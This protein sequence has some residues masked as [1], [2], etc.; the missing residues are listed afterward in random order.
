MK[1]KQT[2]WIVS[3]T[4][5]VATA[6][7]LFA[8]VH[9][10]PEQRK[11]RYL[12]SGQKYAAQGKL[13]EATIQFLNAIELDPR[14]TQAHLELAKVA[15]RLGEPRSA[16]FEYQ[17]AAQLDPANLGAQ[18]QVGK[19]QMLT[20]D[21]AGAKHQANLV[22]EGQPDN[23]EAH[24]LLGDAIA[25]LEKKDNGLP[26]I[27][28]ALEL[29][30][31]RPEPMI[32]LAALQL[33]KGN[34]AKAEENYNS[35]LAADGKSLEALLG[36]ARVKQLQNNPAEAERRIQQAI[37]VAPKDIRP[38][39]ALATLYMVS[40]QRGKAEEAA[41][42]AKAALPDVPAAYRML[43]DVY[44]TTGQT[45]KALDEFAALMKT[46]KDD[47]DLK[48]AETQLLILAGQ[49]KDAQ[50]LNDSVLKEVSSDPQARVERAE[51]LYGQGNTGKTREILQAVVRENPKFYLAHYYLGVVLESMGEPEGARR[52]FEAAAK[53]QPRM[54][55]AHIALGALASELGDL[56]LFNQQVD[57]VLH[58]QPFSAQPYIMRA[59]EFMQQH[60]PQRAEVELKTAITV[61]PQESLPY[62]K[63][64]SF[65]GSQKRFAEAEQMYEQSLQRDPANVEAMKGLIA[66]YYAQGQQSRA[67]PRLDQQIQQVPGGAYHVLR[68]E[69][70]LAAKNLSGAE[71]DLQ[72]ALGLD[73]HNEPAWQLLSQAQL[74]AGK[75]EE[76]LATCKKW[77]QQFPEDAN[78]LVL[79]GELLD[80]AGKWQDAQDSYE[81]ALNIDSTNKAA[82]NDVA[83][84]L[85]EHN[86]DRARAWRLAARA[87]DGSNSPA[88]ADTLAWAEFNSRNYSRAVQLL[89]DAVRKSPDNPT[90]H[91]HL[92]LAYTKLNQSAQ[93]RAE[94]EKVLSLAPSYPHAEEVKAVLQK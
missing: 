55:D 9:F 80:S 69:L 77:S 59:I 58:Q 6:A 33:T 26:E 65:L 7:A 40:G 1:K 84:S 35:A 71:T 14:F 16:L 73:P 4:L 76:A 19:L 64:G 18:L 90:F 20:G 21:A 68:A 36:M 42:A 44:I 23:W 92:G 93:A 82:E 85:L 49:M 25:L 38:R 32:S 83:F 48:I 10:S 53:L 54:A 62:M 57:Q 3:S 31:S 50:A 75:R 81:K 51:I 12:S 94:L 13:R 91:Y 46:H 88:F 43:G 60:Q 17:S 2:W 15:V 63:F 74:M 28:K 79:Q 39:A 87:N 22:L 34:I 72:A 24:L 89:Q 29:A 11:Q 30:P 56:Q 86:G 45:H 41:N 8:A 27:Q 66:A 70:Q 37:E 47:I 52:E 67:L 78:P 5:V 61:A